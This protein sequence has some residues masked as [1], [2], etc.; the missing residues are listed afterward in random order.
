MKPATPTSLRATFS[1]QFNGGPLIRVEDL[2]VEPCSSGVTVLFGPSGSGKTTIL[3][4]LAGLDKPDSGT[5]RLGQEIWLDVNAHVVVPSRKRRI[6]FVPQD[7]ALFPHLT[8]AGNVGYGLGAGSAAER[9]ERVN[10]TLR[11][12]GLDGLGARLPNELSGGQQQRVALARA[13]AMQPKLLLL[14]EPLSALDA[15]TR[16]RLRI[17]L[18]Q[19]LSQL[20][21]PTLLVTHDRT[22]ALALGARI[23]VLNRGRIEQSGPVGEVFNRPANLAVAQIAGVETVVPGRIVERDGGLVT[24][25]VGGVK[26]FA[27]TEDFP[28]DVESVNVCIRAEDV[29]L[30]RDDGAATSARNRLP[31][32]VE[33]LHAEVQ[34]TR[35]EL[36]CGFALKALI[37][38][39]ALAEMDLRP[40]GRL[41]AWVK[42]PHVHLVAN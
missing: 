4:C 26:L 2:R 35:V 37:T 36:N 23:I 8:V 13:V 20:G 29:V 38:R 3:R 5:I 27:L 39:Q 22:E 34:S 41:F 7:F 9:A 16:Q 21:I 31:A 24:V 25:V 18:R 32:I 15:P 42:A 10:R 11:W 40:G 1:R 28:P 17:E 12:L 6:G 19:W 14:D 33:S 30:S